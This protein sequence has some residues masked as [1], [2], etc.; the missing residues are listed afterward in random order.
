VMELQRFGRDVGLE[1]ALVVGQLG[2]LESHIR[3]FPL[4]GWCCSLEVL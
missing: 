4:K 3:L 2:K 1:R